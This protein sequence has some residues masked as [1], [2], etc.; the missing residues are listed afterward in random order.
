MIRES[1]P[2]KR[3]ESKDQLHNYK[4]SKTELVNLIKLFLNIP[5]SYYQVM[6]APVVK[7]V[8]SLILF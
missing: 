2:R 1:L 6:M 8:S 7:V 5:I 3:E 4:L